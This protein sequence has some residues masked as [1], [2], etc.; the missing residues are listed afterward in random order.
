MQGVRGAGRGWGRWG[1]REG[2]NPP[3]PYTQTPDLSNALH[4]EEV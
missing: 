4:N 3:T 1:G 2:F